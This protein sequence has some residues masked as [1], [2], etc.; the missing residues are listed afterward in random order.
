MNRAFLFTEIKERVTVADAPHNLLTLTPQCIIF[1]IDPPL[2]SWTCLANTSASRPWMDN[3]LSLDYYFLIPDH[4]PLACP[5]NASFFIMPCAAELCLLCCLS[6][7]LCWVHISFIGWT[8][9]SEGYIQIWC[10]LHRNEAGVD[11]VEREICCIIIYVL[12]LF[13][14]LLE[15]QL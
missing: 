1:C 2:V 12:R 15:E 6:I 7:C 4:M 9:Q 13:Y 8:L 10:I 3:I 5:T 11:G 14:A